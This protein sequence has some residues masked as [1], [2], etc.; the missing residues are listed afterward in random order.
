MVKCYLFNAKHSFYVNGNASRRPSV[1]VSIYIGA[2][3]GYVG[4]DVLL[5]GGARCHGCSI[6]Q[7]QP[8]I[9]VYLLTMQSYSRSWL[10]FNECTCVKF[11]IALVLLRRQMINEAESSLFTSL[12]PECERISPCCRWFS[13]FFGRIVW[14]LSGYSCYLSWFRK[15]PLW[16]FSLTMFTIN[17]RTG[18]PS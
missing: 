8:L 4:P 6:Q 10:R 15:C 11:W 2:S 12:I 3:I 14:E 5:E 1:A 9:I 18:N 13:V 17:Y 7:Y 16:C